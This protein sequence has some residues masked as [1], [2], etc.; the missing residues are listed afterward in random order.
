MVPDIDLSSGLV[1]DAGVRWR[2]WD[3]VKGREGLRGF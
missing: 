3:G 2:R 1:R